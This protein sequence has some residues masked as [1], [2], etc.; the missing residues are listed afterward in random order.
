MEREL[1]LVKAL[2]SETVQE[3]K[4]AEESP[5]DNRKRMK[6]EDDL[7]IKAEKLEEWKAARKKEEVPDRVPVG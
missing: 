5:S 2:K 3:L 4:F 7:A 1:I 6:I